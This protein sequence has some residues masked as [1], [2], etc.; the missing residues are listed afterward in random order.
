MKKKLLLLTVLVI[1]LTCIFAISVSAATYDKT[2]TVNVTLKDG[3]TQSCALYDA[4]GDELV[5]YTL[6]EGA[7][8]VSVKTKNLI[9]SS[10]TSLA[11][12]SLDADTYLQKQNDNTTNK[13]VVANLRCCTFKTVTHSGY[14][15]TFGDSKIVQ[16]VYLP[17]TVTNFGCNIFQYCSNL[18]VCDIPSDAT[19][20]ID[21]ANCFINCTSLVEINLTGCT[22]IGTSIGCH[23]CFSG[24]TSL[25]RVIIDPDN[26]SGTILAGNLFASCPLTQFGLIPNECHIPDSVVTMG[27][28]VFKN[29]NFTRVYFGESLETTGYN[30]FDGNTSLQEVHFNSNYTTM[31]Q[32]AFMNCT[33]LTRVYGLEKTKLSAIPHEAFINTKIE[34]IILPNTIV[35]IAQSA[36]GAF[37][38]GNNIT[39]TKIVLGAGLTTFTSHD[40]FKNFAALEEVYM[41]AGVTSIPGN[42]FNLSASNCV[43]YFTG[44]KAQL[45]TL[46]ANTNSNNTAFLNAYNNAVDAK[47]YNPE[48]MTGK[49]VVYNYSQCDAFYAGNHTNAV[50]YGFDGEDKYTAN[51]CKFDGCT[52]CTNKTI[53]KYGTLFTNKGYSKEQDGTYFAYTIVFNKDVIELY[54]EKTEGATFSYGVLAAKYT[55]DVSTGD[56]FNENGDTVENCVAIDATKAA[57]SVYSLKITDLDKVENAKAQALYCCAYIVD[58]GAIKYVADEVTDKAATICYNDIEAVIDTTTPPTTGDDQNA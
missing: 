11:H 46:K 34:E 27:V 41:P 16:Y 28:N 18:K 43:F 1:A 10:T 29:S 51:F 13:I 15:S 44:T 50:T 12:I 48:T 3:T 56:L 21:D 32:R 20:S 40:G 25:E 33:S 2:E 52:R 38:A 8:V 9:F 49:I 58:N 6:D 36:F 42:V 17:N 53:T 26:F 23:S 24:C 57:Y 54:L 14:K 4:D 30:V 37:Y 55:Q 45:D 7:T 31:D 47:D 22:K 39:T 35:S 19:F 5:W